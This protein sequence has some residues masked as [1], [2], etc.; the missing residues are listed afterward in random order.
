[1]ELGNDK[2]FNNLLKISQNKTL[3]YFTKKPY[4]LELLLLLNKK[5]EIEGIE[6]TYQLLKSSKPKYPAFKNFLNYLQQNNC[7]FIKDGK[8]KKSYKVL[9]LTDDVKNQLQDLLN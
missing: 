9:S 1:M 3:K 7:V 6:N 2:I 5:T 4:S 8:T